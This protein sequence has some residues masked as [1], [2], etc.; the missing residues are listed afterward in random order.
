MKAFNIYPDGR[1]Q[2]TLIANTASTN[3][4]IRKDAVKTELVDETDTLQ[5]AIS[6][7]QKKSPRIQHSP[8]LGNWRD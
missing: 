6:I 3:A 5:H 8:G 4:A 1:Q 2:E 7:L